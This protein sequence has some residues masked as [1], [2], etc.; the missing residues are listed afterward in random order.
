MSVIA[1]HSKYLFFIYI[2][3]KQEYHLHEV[4]GYSKYEAK[5]SAMLLYDTVTRRYTPLVKATDGTTPDSTYTY[6]KERT[7]ARQV[8]DSHSVALT[9]ALIAELHPP[10]GDWITP[11]IDRLSHSGFTEPRTRDLSDRI[12]NTFTVDIGEDLTSEAFPTSFPRL[13]VDRLMAHFNGDAPPQASLMSQYNEVSPT[14]TFWTAMERLLLCTTNHSHALRASTAE[15]V[16]LRQSL[17]IV[18]RLHLRRYPRHSPAIK[19]TE[20]HLDAD[21]FLHCFYYNWNRCCVADKAAMLRLLHPDILATAY[22]HFTADLP[23]ANDPHSPM[24][25]H[26]VFLVLMRAFLAWLDSDDVTN[27]GGIMLSASLISLLWRVRAMYLLEYDSTTKLLRRLHSGEYPMPTSHFPLN[28]GNAYILVRF[29]RA[30]TWLYYDLAVMSTTSD[31]TITPQP[32]FTC[33]PL[34]SF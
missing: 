1:N 12:E 9:A 20:K 8:L 14:A 16:P 18:V 28:T 22:P 32:V 30:N 7:F 33:S 4:I 23:Y 27:I 17:A 5:R 2:Q 26:A 31:R 3:V 29:T 11:I 13:V 15:T 10:V 19:A 24:Q 21:Y 34:P 6:C 25:Y